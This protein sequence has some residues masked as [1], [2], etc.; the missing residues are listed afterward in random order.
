[1]PALQS[2]LTIL[3]WVILSYL[4]QYWIDLAA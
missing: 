1:M 3:N 4:P 2:I